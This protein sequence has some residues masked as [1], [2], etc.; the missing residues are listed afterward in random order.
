MK[1]MIK[2]IAMVA[3]FNVGL[4]LAVLQVL[5]MLTIAVLHWNHSG[6]WVYMAIWA[7]GMAILVVALV[8]AYRMHR[9]NQKLRNQT[10]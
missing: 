5:T 3:A 2:R 1:E 8:P 7:T 4:V 10:E 9:I 6:D